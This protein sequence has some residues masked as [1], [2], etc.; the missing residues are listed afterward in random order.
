MCNSTF[1]TSTPTSVSISLI[2]SPLAHA[3][4]S[5]L[6]SCPRHALVT[7]A[8]FRNALYFSFVLPLYKTRSGWSCQ[9]PDNPL[10]AAYSAAPEVYT[11]V[12]PRCSFPALAASALGAKHKSLYSLA[13][14]P[15]SIPISNMPSP[16][17]TPH[18]RESSSSSAW[19]TPKTVRHA[20]LAAP[21][22]VFTSGYHG[23]GET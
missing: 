10:P 1:T 9:R 17:N 20:T 21:T 13:I 11:R 8:W 2:F 6:V 23:V 16:R 5:H 15:N 18:R 12:S 22:N 14:K 3:P 19:N 4:A 7:T